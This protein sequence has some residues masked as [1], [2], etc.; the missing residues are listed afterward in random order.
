MKTVVAQLN[1]NA[2]RDFWRPIADRYGICTIKF[3]DFDGNINPDMI[4]LQGAAHKYDLNAMGWRKFDCPIIGSCG[5]AITVTNADVAFNNLSILTVLH[6]EGLDY[7]HA[8][9]LWRD[10]NNKPD[11]FNK[12]RFQKLCADRYFEPLLD[13]RIYDWCFAGQMYNQHDGRYKHYR[14]GLIQELYSKNQNCIIAGLGDW[15]KLLNRPVFHIEQ[16]ELNKSYAKSHVV[17]SID[18]HNGT[19]YSSTRTFESMHGKHLTA[20]YDHDGMGYLKQFIQH[21][22]HA[23]FFKTTD[24]LLDIIKYVKANPVEAEEIRYAGRKLVLEKGWT[25]SAWFEQSILEFLNL[26]DH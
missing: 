9:N 5:D 23:F 1:G 26:R 8:Y 11:F 20:I 15:E 19:G 13:D 24:E 22:V 25:A 6:V 16:P 7:M 10:R 14:I 2:D 3:E 18:A 4:L 17:I 21:G 12:L